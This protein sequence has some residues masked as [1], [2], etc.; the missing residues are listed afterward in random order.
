MCETGRKYTPGEDLPQ[1]KNE[2]ER[3]FRPQAALP[4]LSAQRERALPVNPVPLLPRKRKGVER[5]EE[6]ILIILSILSSPSIHGFHGS[7]EWAA[8]V[9]E[10]TNHEG[11]RIGAKCCLQSPVSC[12]LRQVSP[13]RG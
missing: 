1:A 12:L 11:T 2:W 9:S 13:L 7:E 6:P 8:E 5:K 10:K 4:A 3:T